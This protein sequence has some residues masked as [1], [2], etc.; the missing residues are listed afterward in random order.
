M[1]LSPPERG[2]ELVRVVAVKVAP[3]SGSVNPVRDCRCEA[4]EKSDDPVRA[5]DQG[6][7]F[8]HPL[9]HPSP[10]RR[11][12]VPGSR[13]RPGTAC[14]DG[15]GEL[16]RIRPKGRV[17]LISFSRPWVTRVSARGLGGQ[18]GRRSGFARTVVMGGATRLEPSSSWDR[19]VR[20]AAHGMAERKG[21]REAAAE[22]PS[23]E[24][25]WI[26]LEKKSSSR[27]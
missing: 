20:C 17:R 11:W 14:I 6:R 13:S 4:F 8:R 15:E 18:A 3:L 21:G 24:S 12:P 26:E 19:I 2:S 27:R 1:L 9:N 16:R 5:S 23:G 25:T 7:G 22:R 10:F